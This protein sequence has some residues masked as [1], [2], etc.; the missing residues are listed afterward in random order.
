MSAAGACALLLAFAPCAEGVA[1]QIWVTTADR[2]RLLT[3][4]AD[5]KFVVRSPTQA[6]DRCG[7]GAALSGDGGI[8]S[9]RHRLQRL[10]HRDSAER[11]SARDAPAGAVRSRRWTRTELH[12]DLDRRI[13]FLAQTL[14]SG[15][16]ARR[17]AGSGPRSFFHRSKPCPSVAG[18]AGGARDQS[19]PAH[20]RLAL[21]SARLDEELGEHGGWP[22]ACQSSTRHSRPI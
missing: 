4:E 3:R 22:A 20:R 11:G 14:Q 15:R 10:E 12:P 18:A 2:S 19:G 5:L 13:G 17:S 7:P 21:E 9:R 16:S 8:W 6:R 1:A